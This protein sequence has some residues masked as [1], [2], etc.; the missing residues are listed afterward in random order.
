[1]VNLRPTVVM[2]D[3]ETNIFDATAWE[4]QTHHPW[5]AALAERPLPSTQAQ[6]PNLGGLPLVLQ[7]MGFVPF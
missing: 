2:K 5:S 1:M 3:V 7:G 4:D 6:R